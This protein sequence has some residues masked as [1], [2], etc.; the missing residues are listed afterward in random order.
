MRFLFS[1]IFS[2][3]F[4]RR[5]LY[6]Y[7]YICTYISEIRNRKVID[8]NRKKKKKNETDRQGKKRNK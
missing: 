8:I 4:F 3:I 7:I 5:S 2:F 6:I 1:H